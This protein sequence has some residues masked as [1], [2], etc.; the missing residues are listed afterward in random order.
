MTAFAVEKLGRVPYQQAWDYQKQVHAEVVAGSRPPTLLLLEHPRTIT[1]GRAAKP[2][3]LLLSEA[4]Y[5]AMGIELFQVERGGDVTYHGP[6][7]LVGYPIFPVGRQVRGFLRRLEQAILLVAAS[8]GIPAY[9]SPG[10]AGVWVRRKAPVEGWPDLEEKLCA[11]GVAVRQDVALHG[12]ALNV[13]THLDDFNL[14]VPCGIKD[15]GVT[16]LQRILGH[17]LSM[18]EV[19][20]RVVVAFAQVFPTFAKELV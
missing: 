14:I 11:F 20:E 2:E 6:G 16:S 13:N 1:L 12:F 18:E 3:H 9:P 19:M 8:Y 7:Q 15:K 17:P 5:R 10:Y 4:Q